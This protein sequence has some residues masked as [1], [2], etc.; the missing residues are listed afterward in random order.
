MKVK[1]TCPAP[2]K[3]L[4][5]GLIYDL[6]DDVAL[7]LKLANMAIDVLEDAVLVDVTTNKDI[8]PVYVETQ[9]R[10]PKKEVTHDN[11]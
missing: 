1:I 4:T 7:A 11:G 8:A 9:K 6:P 5:A 3:G 10:K 2:D